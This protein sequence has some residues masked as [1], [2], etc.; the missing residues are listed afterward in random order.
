MENG[1]F[2]KSF[3]LF[4]SLRFKN[5]WVNEFLIWFFFR[6][7]IPSTIF[8]I[9]Y[10]LSSE[11]YVLFRKICLIKRLHVQAEV[12]NLNE[13]RYGQAELFFIRFLKF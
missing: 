4:K 7:F 6:Q 2:Q 3:C 8:R 9:Y 1:Y 12:A 13:E 11:S 5:Q 10:N